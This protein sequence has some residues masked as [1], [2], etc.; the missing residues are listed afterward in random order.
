MSRIPVRKRTCWTRIL[1][2]DGPPV[3]GWNGRPQCSH[4]SDRR[5]S[6][7][8][9]L[10]TSATDHH[11]INKANRNFQWGYFGLSS[12]LDGTW[13]VADWHPSTNFTRSQNEEN[14][15]CKH[16]V[17]SMHLPPIGFSIKR[18]LPNFES[19]NL[20][21]VTGMRCLPN[22]RHFLLSGLDAIWNTL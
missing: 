16:H 17:W 6:T 3:G 15:T 1:L 7:S 21:C 20:R 14:N 12:L 18:C 22:F 9:G 10:W 4:L 13:D 8:R 5:R 19:T 2:P 11:R